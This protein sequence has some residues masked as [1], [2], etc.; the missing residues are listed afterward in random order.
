MDSC[1]FKKDVIN[2]EFNKDIKK[3][4]FN[5]EVKDNVFDMSMEECIFG[6]IYSNQL[7]GSMKKCET[8]NEENPAEFREN[9]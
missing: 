3:C 7:T 9:Q 4:A 8:Y 5:E 1:E 6:K 2:N